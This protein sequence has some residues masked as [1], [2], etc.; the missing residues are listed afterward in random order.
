[1]QKAEFEQLIGNHL[2]EDE[3]SII[4]IVYNYH[5]SISEVHGKKQISDIYSNLGMSVILDMYPRAEKICELEL[6]I[7]RLE[8]NINKV[9]E[10]K[11]E[12]STCSAGEVKDKV[13]PSERQQAIA[14]AIKNVE[15]VFHDGSHDYSKY[16]RDEFMC[17]EMAEKIICK[18]ENIKG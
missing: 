10:L 3:Y 9:K 14:D 17:Q 16:Y 18:L 13:I 6:S 4:E 1:M 8:M 11:Q 5:P 7:R 12:V 2:S 15:H